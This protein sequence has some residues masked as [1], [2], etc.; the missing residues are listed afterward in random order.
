MFQC[1]RV[2]DNGN[3]FRTCLYVGHT[4]CESYVVLCG[5]QMSTESWNAV[6][7]L[8]SYGDFFKSAEELL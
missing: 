7:V 6:F 5:D 4:C 3:T 8:S 2:P 1:V